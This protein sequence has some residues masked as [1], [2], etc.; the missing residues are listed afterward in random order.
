M[1]KSVKT[2]KIFALGLLTM[3]IM[4]GAGLFLVR[5]GVIAV[6][7]A[8]SGLPLVGH[9]TAP[10]SGDELLLLQQQLADKADKISELETSLSA[11]DTALRQSQDSEAYLKAELARLN[12]EVLNLQS[13][14]AGKQATYKDMGS[15]FASMKPKDAADILS[16]LKD[17]DIIGILSAMP[18]E[19][20]A[21]ILPFMDRDQAAAITSKM[22]VTQP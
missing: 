16:R 1:T 22:L 4:A 20:A 12:E 2:V 5:L 10:A 11:A 3:V 6:P 17:D 15:Y 9:S 21:E 14:V 19:T 13:E 8:L 7:P 18:K